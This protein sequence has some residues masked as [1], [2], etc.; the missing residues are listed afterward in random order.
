MRLAQILDLFAEDSRRSVYAGEREVRPA[1]ALV[2]RKV[3]TEARRAKVDLSE[4]F[5]RR[6]TRS[7]HR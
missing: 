1:F 3:S 2:T 6:A 5:G 4:S 7:A